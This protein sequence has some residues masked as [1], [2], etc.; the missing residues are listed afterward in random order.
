MALTR[1]PWLAGRVFQTFVAAQA[2]LEMKNL[3]GRLIQVLCCQGFGLVW[4]GSS[5]RCCWTAG[6]ALG[7]AGRSRDVE[8]YELSV[9]SLWRRCRDFRGWVVKW[10]D[11]R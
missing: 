8:P 5:D 7:C 4:V 2:E 1:L 3:A 9:E 6:V 11:K 10:A